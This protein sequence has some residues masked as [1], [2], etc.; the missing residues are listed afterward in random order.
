MAA[1]LSYPSS[2]MLNTVVPNQVS[3]VAALPGKR[4]AIQTY[5]HTL[6][7]IATFVAAACLSTPTGEALTNGNVSTLHW[8]VKVLCDVWRD[9]IAKC[10]PNH[11]PPVSAGSLAAVLK[12]I[13]KILCMII[14]LE[15]SVEK[16][17][18]LLQFPVECIQDLLDRPIILRNPDIEM[19][20]VLSCLVII[21]ATKNNEPAM[22]S[23]EI[24]L[25]PKLTS[26][27]SNTSV[28]E[29]FPDHICQPIRVLMHITGPKGSQWL[30]SLPPQSLSW[31]SEK[32]AQST[33]GELWRNLHEEQ[34]SVEA[35]DEQPSRKRLRRE[36][37]RVDGNASFV[38]LKDLLRG[39]DQQL[40]HRVEG[41]FADLEE[42]T[43]PRVFELIGKCF[44][45]HA[46][47]DKSSTRLK[48]DCISCAGGRMK[49]GKGT[50]NPMGEDREKCLI[51]ILIVL[52]KSNTVTN[53]NKMKIAAMLAVVRVAC[54]TSMIATLNI[55]DG[56]LG[57]WCLQC[58]R[59]QSRELRLA[60]SK[61]LKM[62]LT[63]DYVSEEE[64][65]KQNRITALNVL[66]SLSRADEIRVF[67]TVVL[68]FGQVAQVCQE[69]ELNLILLQLIDYLGNPNA[70]LSSLAYLEIQNIAVKRNESVEDLIRP[71]WRT[72]AIAAV[73]DLRKR[74]QKL[75][76]LAEL[77]SWSVSRLLRETQEFTLPYLVLWGQVEVLQRMA[78]EEGDVNIWD[79]C[80]R[81]KNLSAVLALLLSQ[82]PENGEAIVEQ[83]LKAV[84]PD[85]NPTEI[86]SLFKVD[87]PAVAR[88][89]LLMACQTEDTEKEKVCGRTLC[90]LSKYNAN[91][92]RLHKPSEN[93]HK[94]SSVGAIPREV[95]L[96]KLAWYLYSA[97]ITP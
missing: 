21:C 86:T 89:L 76:H 43:R 34:V 4:V 19:S 11:A 28:F 31:V 88:L 97:K 96:R 33:I 75:Q 69:D 40:P 14:S 18:G 57:K 53:S 3:L 38:E 2:A 91:V 15:K 80:L 83:C 66:R 39:W 17:N 27:S 92:T 47:A 35:Q 78:K 61:A 8:G 37:I 67:E 12:S 23:V 5:D 22:Y 44:C 9:S 45:N 55:N 52:I 84:K 41:N 25:K 50:S 30:K 68:A 1:E 63:S 73:K 71:Y 24:G 26:F 29:T 32:S 81:P 82:H 58:L 95:R 46:A 77:L 72:I 94:S 65:F 10:V 62:F 79:L 36:E 59:S 13:N 54:H 60:S 85:V 56:E 20:F 93:M 87:P 48:P 64:T 90:S 7:V 16:A 6:G 51:D 49:R 74:P 70:L 42:E